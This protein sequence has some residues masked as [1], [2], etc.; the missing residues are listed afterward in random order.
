MVVS[1]RAGIL[2]N[3]QAGEQAGEADMEALMQRQ[4]LEFGIDPETG[5]PKDEK[6]TVF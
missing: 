1:R 6:L 2:A 5:L 4:M 3:G